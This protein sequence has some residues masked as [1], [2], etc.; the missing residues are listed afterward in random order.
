MARHPLVW[1]RVRL[2]NFRIVYRLSR[3]LRR[4]FTPAGR[5]VLSA[6]LGAGA[7]GIDTRVSFASAL[8]SLG[9]ALL[10]VSALTLPLFRDRFLIRRTLP[11]YATEGVR[12]HYRVEVHNRGRHP[13]HDLILADQL[14]A[15]WPGAEEFSRRRPPQEQ[16]INWFDRQVGFP[17]FVW[18]TRRRQGATIKE[19]PVPPV[20]PG[21]RVDV[22]VEALPLR[23]GRLRFRG[24]RVARPDPLGLM[25]GLADA[26]AGDDLLVLPRRHPVPRL[27]LPGPRREHP[28]GV[29]FAGH[30]GESEEFVAVR[31][32]RPG[33]PVRHIH[34]RGWARTG[35]PV[36]KEYR[37]EYFVRY[38]LVLDTF[39]HPDDPR[40]EAAVS[41]AASYACTVDTREALLDLVFV[42]H[43]VHRL[44]AGRGV[45]GNEH[46]LEVL[47]CV[48]PAAA[49]S[50]GDLRHS[51]ERHATGLSAAL[52][53]LVGWDPDRA[54]L[55]HGLARRGLPLLTLVVSPVPL[56]EVATTL[57]A[58]R[59][60]PAHLAQDLAAVA[61]PA[62]PRPRGR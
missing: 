50:L 60:R 24:A 58:R 2:W 46:L 15:G 32:Y 35:R 19:V 13:Q 23:R 56:P 14:A 12:L 27:D 61:S 25:R 10:L 37:D 3:L 40:F 34:W 54:D 59:L 6:T 55:V 29:A 4:R 9:V 20:A 41:A 38:A 18:L 21:Q 31:D 5:V 45:G 62:G 22:E 42:G 43:R 48:E 57:G 1:A 33:D 39:C 49:G 28:G 47:A 8:F 7:L 36:V 17:R 53:V 51:L 26:P 16:R 52:L 30:V 44:T 11:R